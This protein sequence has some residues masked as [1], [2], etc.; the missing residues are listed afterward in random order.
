MLTDSRQIAQ[1]GKKVLIFSLEMARN[2]LIAK[3]VSRLTLL[4]DLSK[5]NS[6]AHAKT[7]R[8]ILTG[9]RYSEYSESEKQL[10]QTAI[11]QYGQYASNIWITEGIGNITVESIREK[12][13]QFIALYKA[14]VVII[15]YLRL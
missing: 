7:T 14:P 3:S 5:N 1:A 9:T 10:I 13:E 15:D 11:T 8:G 4:E 2:E 6:T 12:V